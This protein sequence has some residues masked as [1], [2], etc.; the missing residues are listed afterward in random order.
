MVTGSCSDPFF[1]FRGSLMCGTVAD[2]SRFQMSQG[3]AVCGSE[4]VARCFLRSSKEQVPGRNGRVCGCWC[5]TEA[6][7]RQ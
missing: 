7:D 5:A 2:S 1:L 6:G 4:S 3:F